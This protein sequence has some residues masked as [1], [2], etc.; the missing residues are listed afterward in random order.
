MNK[1]IKK[2]IESHTETITVI[3]TAGWDDVL[4]CQSLFRFQAGLGHHISRGTFGADLLQSCSGGLSLYGL[5]KHVRPF[6]PA[7]WTGMIRN[8]I[9]V[10]VH[11]LKTALYTS[12]IKEYSCQSAV[13][14]TDSW[15]SY[16]GNPGQGHAEPYLLYPHPIPSAQGCLMARW[17]WSIFRGVLK[18]QRAI[19]GA[20]QSDLSAPVCGCC[21]S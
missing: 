16:T 17:I 11:N 10:Y 1:E 6:I 20:T 7:G 13:Y 4:L 15:P 19:L 21:A 3:F 2:S 8:S 9:K 14:L 18:T 12:C 5:R